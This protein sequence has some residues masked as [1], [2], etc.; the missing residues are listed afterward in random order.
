[1][2][3]TENPSI[4]CKSSNREV[5]RN[6][7]APNGSLWWTAEYT[8]GSRWKLHPWPKWTHL[9]SFFCNPMLGTPLKHLASKYKHICSICICTSQIHQWGSYHATSQSVDMVWEGPSSKGEEDISKTKSLTHQC[10]VGGRMGGTEPCFALFLSSLK[11]W[12]QE[13]CWSYDQH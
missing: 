4:Y 11:Y 8:E 1:M 2:E 13:R 5:K 7:L 10:C 6:I 12:W 9:L 3:E